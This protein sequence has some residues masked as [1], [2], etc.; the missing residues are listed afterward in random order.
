VDHRE[1]K[2]ITLMASAAGPCGFTVK[3][4]ARSGGH[5]DLAVLDIS[6]GG[7]MVDQQGLS[8]RQGERVLLTLPGLAAQPASV[9]WI[10]EGKAGI[11]FEHPLY[12]AVLNLLQQR[13][14]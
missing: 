9:V 1:W 7:C 11:A 3:C 14:R 8:A 12:D 5:V 6:A 13:R 4:R 2:V 10:E